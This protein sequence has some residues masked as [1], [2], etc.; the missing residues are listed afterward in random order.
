MSG[1]FVG[2]FHQTGFAA[3]SLVL[4]DNAALGRLVNRLAGETDCL[5]GRGFGNGGV[6]GGARLLDEGL[7]GR[8]GSDVPQVVFAGLDDIFL[9]GLDIGHLITS[10]KQQSIP[11]FA[12]KRQGCCLK[13]VKNLVLDICSVTC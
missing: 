3:G 5:C 9:D 8:L 11:H 2:A 7:H 10:S 13:K 6:D 4:V 12:P 1:S